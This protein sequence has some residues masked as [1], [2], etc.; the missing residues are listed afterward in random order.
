MAYSNGTVEILIQ[1]TNHPYKWYSHEDWEK[2]IGTLCAAYQKIQEA[3][4]I[5]HLIHDSVLDWTVTQL[6]MNHDFPEKEERER[7]RKI[8]CLPHT[9]TLNIFMLFIGHI[10]TNYHIKEVAIVLKKTLT[11]FPT[12][13]HLLFHP[14]LKLSYRQPLSGLWMLFL[15]ILLLFLRNMLLHKT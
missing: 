12:L 2:I 11:F 8:T 14:Y 5:D 9:S 6:D 7:Q 1:S 13:Q 4:S 15:S 3:T 10:Q